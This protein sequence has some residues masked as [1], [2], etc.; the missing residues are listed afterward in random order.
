M[1]LYMFL[2]VCVIVCFMHFIVDTF[3]LQLYR[4]ANPYNA[5]QLTICR[6]L[7][8]FH[9]TTHTHT[10]TT[11]NILVNK[12]TN[13]NKWETLQTTENAYQNIC[14][15]VHSHICICVYALTSKNAI[16]IKRKSKTELIGDTYAV[17]IKPKQGWPLPPDVVVND[18]FDLRRKPTRG[19]PAATATAATS[20]SELNNAVDNSH[21]MRCRYCAMQFLKVSYDRWVKR[22]ILGRT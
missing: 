6:L 20:A 19:E 10:H 21:I 22:K 2:C 12:T 1:S 4:S 9:I 13:N 5:K 18:L 15:Y 16:K 3:Q 8:S 11:T 7:F 14:I 17:E